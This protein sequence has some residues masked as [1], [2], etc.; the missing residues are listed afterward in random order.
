MIE[1][2]THSEISPYTHGSMLTR[3]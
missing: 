3:L 2:T 1:S